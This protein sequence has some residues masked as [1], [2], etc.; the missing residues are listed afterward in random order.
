VRPAV[1]VAPPVAIAARLVNAYA[2]TVG[3]WRELTLEVVVAVWNSNPVAFGPGGRLDSSWTRDKMRTLERRMAGAP[4]DEIGAVAR[5]VDQKA[6]ADFSRLLTGT[7]AERDKRGKLLNR[8]AV[9]LERVGLQAHL[10]GKVE[11]FKRANIAKIETIRGKQL[12]TFRDILDEA[13]AGGW[14]VEQLR[15]RLLDDLDI[16]QSR[17]ELIA[18]DQ[19]LKLAGDIAQERQMQSGIKRYVW[20]T[21]GDERVRGTPGGKWPRGMHYE[22]DGEEF[23][24]DDPPITNEA[25]DRNHPGQDYQCRCIAIPVLPD[26]GESDE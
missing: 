11:Q 5:R 15:N 9:Q 24:W 3:Q 19:T 14:R 22:L 16:T 13:E 6:A 2:A 20:R 18:R 10:G 21:S 26:F 12:D 1:H 25:G 23:S 8:K 17:A 4:A 7:P